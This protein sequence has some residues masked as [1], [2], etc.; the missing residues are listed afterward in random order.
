MA[1][2]GVVRATRH[3]ST[4]Y[5]LLNSLICTVS[6]S[7]AGNVRITLPYSSP[8][9]Y[10]STA[11]SSAALQSCACAQLQISAIT[12]LSSTGSGPP[13]TVPVEMWGRLRN[14]VLTAPNP[15]VSFTV[16][17]EQFGNLRE[18][19]RQNMRPRVSIMPIGQPCM[20]DKPKKRKDR[21]D[22]VVPVPSAE[23]AG[24]QRSLN[25]PPIPTD[26][27]G[28]ITY[29]ITTVIGTLV[30]GLSNIVGA[31]APQAGSI[32][33]GLAAI[34]P[35]IVLDKPQSEVPTQ[36]TWQQPPAEH[37]TRGL[38]HAVTM[39][40]IPGARC[41]MEITSQVDLLRLAQL[42]NFFQNVTYQAGTTPGSLLLSFPL[43]YMMMYNRTRIGAGPFTYTLNISPSGVCAMSYSYCSGGVNVLLVA[44]APPNVAYRIAVIQTPPGVVPPASL[45]TNFGQYP[46]ASFEGRGP[47]KFKF[48]APLHAPYHI[49]P[50]GPVT[51]VAGTSNSIN[52]GGNIG[53]YML[54][55]PTCNDVSANTTCNLMVWVA[56]DST[57][58]FYKYRGLS[59]P[60]LT[61]TSVQ[62]ESLSD[63]ELTEVARQ[64]DLAEIDSAE[65]CMDVFAEF[66]GDFAPLIPGS[67]SGFSSNI[68]APD[69]ETNLIG[70]L[71]RPGFRS[72]FTAPTTCPLDVAS[73]PTLVVGTDPF[74]WWRGSLIY[75]LDLGT[76]AAG[77][78][79]CV[80][81]LD[82]VNANGV[83]A[84]YDAGT[85]VRWSD[86]SPTC[87]VE[88]PW[89]SVYLMKQPSNETFGVSTIGL[90]FSS[91]TYPANSNILVS[92]GDNFG[93]AGYAG[94]SQRIIVNAVLPDGREFPF[95]YSVGGTPIF[96][97]RPL[98]KAEL[99]RRAILP[100]SPAPQ[101]S[102]LSTLLS[103]SPMKA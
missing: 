11:L 35:A 38:S 24:K 53:V 81:I 19:M 14:V 37:F 65:A 25:A 69:E 22:V 26:I 79:Q 43:N 64:V 90:R 57:T 59:N 95:Y 15:L 7:T 32:M 8:F 33:K 51:D 29:G 72:T 74:V 16:R 50:C 36:L 60:N 44:D 17:E 10:I 88:L 93:V 41:S 94:F 101:P 49:I 85:I 99:A 75:H 58:K 56:A 67:K 80:S 83:A 42:P 61:F 2:P 62:L 27:G 13:T 92:V 3:G 5:Q 9:K 55:S 86:Q 76:N 31:I 73:N 68:F 100:R 45:Y 47:T 1:Y 28:Q 4:M 46:T 97:H 54:Q 89:S 98:V 48:N 40:T 91:A 21:P 77:R 63:F 103:E 102:R 52:T 96:D 18:S 78:Y 6:A 82:N 20:A 23:A 12:P 70:L 39:S 84:D 34:A 66:N 30:N 87:S 71:K